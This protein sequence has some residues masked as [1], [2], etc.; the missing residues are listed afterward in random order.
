MQNPKTVK[1]IAKKR[2]RKAKET[3]KLNQ[4]TK[5]S[6]AKVEQEQ[7]DERG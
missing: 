2:A 3:L 5:K 7:E 1:F 4:V 6:K